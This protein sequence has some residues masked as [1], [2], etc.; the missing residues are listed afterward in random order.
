MSELNIGYEFIFNLAV[1]KK[2]GKTYKTHLAAGI[3]STYAHALWYACFTLKKKRIEILK[4]N[5]ARVKRI[6]FAI[7]D[8][9][10]VPAQLAEFPAEIPEDLNNE[11]SR[12]TKIYNNGNNP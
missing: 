9:Q 4:V 6:A 5:S 11:L 3:G 2:N 8:G 7:R 1:K 12:L 10:S